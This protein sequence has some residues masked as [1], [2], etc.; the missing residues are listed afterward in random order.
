MTVPGTFNN[1]IGDVVEIIIPTSNN[2]L[3][4]EKNISGKYLIIKVT[5]KIMMNKFVQQITIAR[6]KNK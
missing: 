5:D 1:N 3:D 4:I 6:A 2:K